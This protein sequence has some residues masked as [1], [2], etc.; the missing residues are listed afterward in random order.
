V[1]TASS[2]YI[3]ETIWA[4]YFTAAPRL[5]TPSELRY[6]RLVLGRPREPLRHARHQCANYMEH[7]PERQYAEEAK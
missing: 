7:K 4:R 6:R 2:A 3:S 1:V 5:R